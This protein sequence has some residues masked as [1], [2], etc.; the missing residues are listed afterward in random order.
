MHL[1]INSS[2]GTI[3]KHLRK[4]RFL[5]ENNG[6][7]R[8]SVSGSLIYV[9]IPSSEEL[10]EIFEKVLFKWIVETMQPFK[11]FSQESFQQLRCSVPL[12]KFQVARQFK[13]V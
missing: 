13:G 12:R 4:H 3:R 1:S 7:L 10:Q 5:L 6:Q 9:V 8:F 11:C 2:T